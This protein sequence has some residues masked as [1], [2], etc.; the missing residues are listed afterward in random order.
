MHIQ[1]QIVAK[2]GG[3]EREMWRSLSAPS[4][5]TI[6]I[7]PSLINLQTRVVVSTYAYNAT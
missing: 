5:S 1:G 2:L 6:K 7:N 4:H 3:G